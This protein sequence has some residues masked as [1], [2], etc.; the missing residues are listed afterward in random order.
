MLRVTSSGMSQAT[1]AVSAEVRSLPSVG[2]QR[3]DQAVMS[4]CWRLVG[5]PAKAGLPTVDPSLTSP[6][7]GFPLRPGSKSGM[8]EHHGPYI[9]MPLV[10]LGGPIIGGPTA[11]ALW[12][13]EDRPCGETEQA[14]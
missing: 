7:L 9:D 12:H 1:D 13:S 3:K 14:M 5:L 10:P 6:I 11:D 2:L 8:R 4:A